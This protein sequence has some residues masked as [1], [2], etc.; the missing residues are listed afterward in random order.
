MRNFEPICCVLRL[1]IN[2]AA[3]KYLTFKRDVKP[4]TIRSMLLLQ[5][6]DYKV[7]D[8]SRKENLV[9]DHLSFLPLECYHSEFGPIDDSYGEE[10]LY[11]VQINGA[12]W[13]SNIANYLTCGIIP[14]GRNSREKKIFYEEAKYYYWDDPLLFRLFSNG[15]YRR[16]ISEEK[17]ASVIANCHSLPCWGHG[18]V[19]KIVAK[20]PEAGSF[21]P[22]LYKDVNVFVKYC[23]SFQRMGNIGRRH[24]MPQN[25]ILECKIFDIWGLDF[26]G[27]FVSSLGS[28]YIAC[29]HRLC[30]H[31]SQ[32]SFISHQ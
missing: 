19:M 22:T 16:C 31:V 27:P 3:L 6:L 8:K 29:S 15:I 7:R 24:E 20:I 14:K 12:Q 5:E 30:F 25:N 13:F 9:V 28:V 10:A 26:M 2:H 18:G 17:V 1:Y 23:D 32:C 21:W 11:A 4:R